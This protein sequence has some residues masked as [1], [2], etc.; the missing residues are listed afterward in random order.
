MSARTGRLA[1]LRLPGTGTVGNGSADISTP[2]VRRYLVETIFGIL[3]LPLTLAPIWWYMSHN[4]NGYLMWLRGE[5]AIHAPATPQL[6]QTDTKLAW[7][8]GK[9]RAYG[10]PVLVYH[11]IG[12]IVSDVH[13]QGSG[14]YVVS[15]KNFAGQ[16]RALEAAGYQPIT[17]ADLSLYLKSGDQS[18]LPSKPVLVTFDDGRSDAMIQADPILQDTNMKATMFVIGEDAGSQSFYYESWGRLASYASSG[19]WTLENHTFGLHHIHDFVRF[20]HPVGALVDPLKGETVAKYTKRVEVDLTADDQAIADHTG[21]HPIA[22]AYPFSDWGQYSK[23]AISSALKHV[24][25]DHFALAFDDAQQSGW[26]PVLAGDDTMHLHRLEVMNWTA[27]Q[28]IQRLSA[29][30][31]L[32]RTVYGERGL[33]FATT[34]VQLA[35]AAQQMQCPAP[36]GQVVRN[37]FTHR[38]LVAFGFDDG[39]SPF[40]PQILDLLDQYKAQASFFIFGREAE[41]HTRLLQRMIVSGDEIGVHGWD[42][43]F[44]RASASDSS[45]A[46]RF[47]QSNDAIKS[48][49]SVSPCLDRAAFT[50]DDARSLRIAGTLGKTVAGWSVDPT[51]YRST[52][53]DK[54]AKQVL[55]QVYPGAIVVMHD[56]GNDQRWATVQAF[57]KILPALQA[58]GYQMV[59]ISRLVRFSQRMETIKQQ[60]AAKTAKKHRVRRKRTAAKK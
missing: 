8:F 10:V 9:Q 2:S 32:S 7:A 43:T 54:I 39:P 16:M 28:F 37:I 17:P 48:A 27:V 3:M 42:G 52:N 40:T 34:P 55:D 4:P 6:N 49:V 29:A 44:D 47:A 51:D 21:Q 15:R 38:K 53:P 23:P 26:R 25:H 19:R 35:S 30:D 45:I 58:R 31:K 18:V 1:R 46:A 56:G 50:N 22:F 14:R 11:G 33:G 41:S 20:H 13:E 12:K 36:T 60:R 5:Y 59:T 57:A 24:L